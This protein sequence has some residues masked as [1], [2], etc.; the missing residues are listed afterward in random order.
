M[1]D[2]EVI[3]PSS[4]ELFL[5]IFVICEHDTRQMRTTSRWNR[6]VHVKL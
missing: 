1:I 2:K 3:T 4:R 6:T 5:M